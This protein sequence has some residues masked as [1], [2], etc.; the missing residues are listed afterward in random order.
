MK[1]ISKPEQR[2]MYRLYKEAV[3]RESSLSIQVAF[4]FGQTPDTKKI[5]GEAQEKLDHFAEFLEEGAVT[6]KEALMVI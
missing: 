2:E 3:M 6:E 1:K 5:W 4:G